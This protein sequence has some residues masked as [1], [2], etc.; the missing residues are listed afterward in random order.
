[1]KTLTKIMTLTLLALNLSFASAAEKKIVGGPKGGR[2]LDSEPLRAEFF[3][4]KDRRVTIT[5]YD[6]NLKPVAA[7]EQ[8]VGIIAE[9]K[10][11]KTKLEMEM[12]G[13]ALMSKTP[14]PE[15]ENYNVVVQIKSTPEA[16][17]K[18]FRIAL[19]THTCGEC[20][21]AEYACTCEH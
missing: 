5:F 1:M 18:N 12:K 6:Q 3:I 7:G 16:K 20:Q 14:L 15:G 13:D 10:S 9:P 17:P 19:D 2:L 8:T 4:E 11:G 21:R